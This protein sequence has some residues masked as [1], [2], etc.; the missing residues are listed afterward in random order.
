MNRR[1]HPYDWD[2]FWIHFV[3]EPTDTRYLTAVKGLLREE[4]VHRLV[5]IA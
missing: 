3:C 1:D 5:R 2:R 4:V